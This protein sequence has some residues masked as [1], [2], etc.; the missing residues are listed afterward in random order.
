MSRN[1]VTNEAR[2]S[3]AGR[4]SAAVAFSAIPASFN[5]ASFTPAYTYFAGANAYANTHKHGGGGTWSTIG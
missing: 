3:A 4:V 5:A 1:V 2:S